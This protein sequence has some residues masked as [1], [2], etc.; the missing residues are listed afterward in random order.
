METAGERLILF[1]LLFLHNYNHTHVE[2]FYYFNLV[3]NTVTVSRYGRRRIGVYAKPATK[4]ISWQGTQ[5]CKE[6]PHAEKEQGAQDE[7]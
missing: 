7:S 3:Q 5:A 2:D 1:F 4:A 6:M